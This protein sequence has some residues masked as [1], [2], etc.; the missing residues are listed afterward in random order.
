MHSEPSHTRSPSRH[1]A[2]PRGPSA[3]SKICSSEI[4]SAFSGS[5]ASW[6]GN[7][8]THWSFTAPVRPALP[9][10]AEDDWS[11][12]P[13]DRFVHRQLKQKGWTPAPPAPKAAIVSGIGAKEVGFEVRAPGFFDDPL[14]RYQERYWDGERW[15]EYVKSANNRFIDPL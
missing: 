10:D 9:Q 7:Y 3:A 11:I 6:G 13:L 15:T 8:Q 5:P 2:S 14:G 4:S 1:S 12:R